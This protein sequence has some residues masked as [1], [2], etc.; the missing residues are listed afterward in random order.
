MDHF[1]APMRALDRSFSS[2]KG[3]L[4]LFGSEGNVLTPKRVL[5]EYFSSRE[6][7]LEH[8]WLPQGHYN[9]LYV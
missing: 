3:I 7:T 8:F 5:C 1:L 9:V 4:E 2:C 6:G